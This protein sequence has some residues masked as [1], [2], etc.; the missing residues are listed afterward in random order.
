MTKKSKD[1]ARTAVNLWTSIVAI[2][3]VGGGGALLA[4]S[5]SLD[6]IA[7]P[8]WAGLTGQVGGLF[9]GTGLLAVVWELVAKRA[10]AEEILSKT[11]LRTDLVTSGITRVTDQYLDEVEWAELFDGARNVDIVVAYASTWRNTHHGRLA[12]VAQKSGNKIRVFLPDPDDATTV[13][14]LS[15][16]FKMTPADVQNRIRAAI[17]DFKSLDV[18]KAKVE[19]FTRAGDCLFSCYRFDGKSVLTLYSHSQERRAS[20][21]TF[22]MAGGALS[23]FVAKD[24]DAIRKQST[25][26]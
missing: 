18:G 15:D 6:A 21:P 16:R 1:S 2:V 10:F 26:S 23:E 12:T 24:I 17:T 3:F 20:V 7:L 19:I 13:K 11:Q 22:V 5:S 8:W 14:I 4:Y 9:F 25:A